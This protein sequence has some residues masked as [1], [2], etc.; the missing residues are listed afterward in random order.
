M[1]MKKERI[2]ISGKRYLIYYT[3]SKKKDQKAGGKEGKK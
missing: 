2:E 1:E 3:F